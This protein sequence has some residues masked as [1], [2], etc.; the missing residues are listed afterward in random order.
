MSKT[1]KSSLKSFDYQINDVT[2]TVLEKNAVNAAESAL[3]EYL[4]NEFDKDSAKEMSMLNLTI[5]I[6]GKEKE[7]ETKSEE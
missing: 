5:T 2:G 6:T 3:V 4:E 1:R 7:A